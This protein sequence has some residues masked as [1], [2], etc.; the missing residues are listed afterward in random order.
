MYTPVREN[1]AY[2]WVVRRIFG[3]FGRLEISHE[4]G[5]PGFNAYI[6]RFPEQKGCVVV[7][8]NVAPMPV[9][10]IAVGLAA[11]VWGER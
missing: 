11:I 5:L 8:S 10:Q 3:L 2:G 1:Y 4:G 6:L 7:L 9:R